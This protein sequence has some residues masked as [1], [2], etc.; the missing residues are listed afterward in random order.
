ML[1]L[2][3][4]KLNSSRNHQVSSENEKDV[5]FSEDTRRWHFSF[6]EEANSLCSEVEKRN[7]MERT[8]RKKNHHVNTQDNTHSSTI[9]LRGLKFIV[10]L[11]NISP[12]CLLSP[13]MEI[14]DTVFSHYT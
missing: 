14:R 9:L 10:E 2:V 12:Y 6:S 7:Q 4:E 8:N 11:L 3:G 5:Q 1:I 13:K